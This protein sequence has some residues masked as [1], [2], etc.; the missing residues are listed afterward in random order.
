MKFTLLLL[1]PIFSFGQG[2]L[3]T[4]KDIAPMTLSFAAG[5]ATGWRDV[6]IYHPNQLF[7]QFPNLNENFW[8]NRVQNKPGFLNMEWNADHVFKSASKLFFVT[9]VVLKV[10][11]KKKWYW[12]LW[13]GV[14]YFAAYHIGFFTSYNLINKNKL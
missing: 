3:F 2:Q 12:Y 10:G 9:A 8:D 7:E 11:D 13:D 1:L 5:H 4:K 14:K 6:V